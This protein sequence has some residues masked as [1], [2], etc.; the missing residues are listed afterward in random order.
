MNERFSFRWFAFSLL[1]G[2]GGAFTGA[3]LPVLLIVALAAIAFLGICKGYSYAAIPF[4]FTLAGAYFGNAGNLPA[5]IGVLA[6]VIGTTAALIL[7]FKQHTAYRYIALVI[8]VLVFAASYFALGGRSLA[9]GKAPYNE[10]LESLN[11]LSARLAAGGYVWEDL[12][13]LRESLPEVFYGLLIL[14]AEAAAFLTVILTKRFCTLGKAQIKPMAKFRYWQ[15]PR[16]LKIGL[17]IIVAAT[18]LLFILNQ[19]VAPTLAYTAAYMLL[20]I[21]VV[22]GFACV[23]FFVGRLARGSRLIGVIFTALLIVFPMLGAS[24]GVIDLYTGSRRKIARVDKLIGEAFETAEREKRDSVVVDFG[25]GRGPQVIAVRKKNDD[26]FFDD[27]LGSS[28]DEN[29]DD[30]ETTDTAAEVSSGD[31]IDND[32]DETADETPEDAGAY[33]GDTTENQ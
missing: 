11:E 22:I 12:E 4:V 25:D 17:I 14:F 21:F 8:A 18:V 9:A 10:M 23:R 1:I 28:A 5:L 3:F 20:P 2:I 31:C 33:G 29:P 19:P 32:S 13:L 24:F 26:V 15:L 16:S 27:E 30:T 7:G 6:V